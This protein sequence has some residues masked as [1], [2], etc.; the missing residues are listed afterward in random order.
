MA[1]FSKMFGRSAKNPYA[2]IVAKKIQSISKTPKVSRAEKEKS[3]YDQFLEM[4]GRIKKDQEAAFK[5]AKEETLDRQEPLTDPDDKKGDMLLT[6]WISVS[7]SNVDAIR[8]V[9]GEFGLNIRFLSGWLY[10]FA[11][12]YAMFESMLNAPSK[13]K[14]VWQLRR[15]Q[16]PYRRELPASIPPKILYPWGAVGVPG[17]VATYPSPP[18][19]YN[20]NWDKF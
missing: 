16:V 10:Y 9:G 2:S 13:G 18:P 20:Q 4:K 1:L 15:S 19:S 14:F 3:S 8:W 11:V 12:P 17:G 6:D 5:K 7:S